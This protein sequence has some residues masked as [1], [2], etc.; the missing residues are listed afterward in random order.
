MRR[1]PDKLEPE[2]Q[3]RLAAYLADQPMVG[4]VYEQL[5]RL[6]ALLRHR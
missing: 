5:Q 4:A 6:M 2:Q 3:Q 1:R